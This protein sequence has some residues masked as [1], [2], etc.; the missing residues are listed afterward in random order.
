[1]DIG[2]WLLSDRAVEL[3][4]KRSLDKD[5][6]EIT[7]YDLYSDYGLALGSH[8]KTIDE[9]LNSLSVAILPLPEESFIITE[10]VVS[11]FLL[12]WPYRIKF[13]TSVLSCIGR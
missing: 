2:I 1:M 10:Q 12:R 6:G 5:T 9:E 8:P 3:L 4:M 13:A 11:L 7:Y